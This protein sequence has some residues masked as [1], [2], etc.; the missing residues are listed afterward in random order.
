MGV[1]I[2]HAGRDRA[3]CGVWGVGRVVEAKPARPD[4]SSFFQNLRIR[5]MWYEPKSSSTAAIG[6]F[7][8]LQ[9]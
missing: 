7:P 2:S 5:A 8:Q 3:G 4:I 1:S 9:P 6:S